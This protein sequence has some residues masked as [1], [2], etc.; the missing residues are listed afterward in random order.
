MNRMFLASHPPPSLRVSITADT[1][2]FSHTPIPSHQ[3]RGAHSSLKTHT[4]TR[5]HTCLSESDPWLWIM[6]EQTEVRL[7]ECPANT[8]DTSTVACPNIFNKSGRKRKLGQSQNRSDITGNC[9]LWKY[10][11]GDNSLKAHKLQQLWSRRLRRCR[12]SWEKIICRWRPCH[13]QPDCQNDSFFWGV[14]F[15]ILFSAQVLLGSPLSVNSNPEFTVSIFKGTDYKL[16]LW[17]V[18]A[19]NVWLLFRFFVCVFFADCGI[20]YDAVIE[21]DVLLVKDICCLLVVI[22]CRC[23]NWHSLK[24]TH[25]IYSTK[26]NLNIY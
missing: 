14:S 7:C 23:S 8:G 16:F 17:S 6:E 5:T 3:G 1:L 11:L 2:P 21:R 10:F 4:H 19:G 24:H 15:R 26:K 12:G 25:C 13:P 18:T 9:H 20:I 22:A